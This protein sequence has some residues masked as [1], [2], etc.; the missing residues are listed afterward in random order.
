MN[1]CPF[2]SFLDSPFGGPSSWIV[3]WTMVVLGV[4]HV[5]PLFQAWTN[6][7]HDAFLAKEETVVRGPVIIWM[8]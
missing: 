1:E 5:C 4:V 2:I 6:S 8:N 7:H 3:V